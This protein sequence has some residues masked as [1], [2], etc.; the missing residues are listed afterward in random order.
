MVLEHVAEEL[1]EGVDVRHENEACQQQPEVEE[2]AGKDIGVQDQRQEVQPGQAASRDAAALR[3]RNSLAHVRPGGLEEALGGIDEVAVARPLQ[4]SQQDDAG[5]RE[6]RVGEPDGGTGRQRT[7]LRQA[8]QADQ[9]H[10]VQE[11]QENRD[12]ESRG[13]ARLARRSAQGNADHSQQHAGERQREPAVQLDGGVAGLAR[14]AEDRAGI[15]LAERPHRVRVGRMRGLQRLITG[16]KAGADVDLGVLGRLVRAGVLEVKLDAVVLDVGR[17]D[18]LARQSDGRS[19]A[20]FLAVGGA[21][22]GGA[23]I[24]DEDITPDL[25]PARNRILHI[26]NRV[27]ELLLEDARL[28]LG[29]E[30]LGGQPAKQFLGLADG[31]PQRAGRGDHRKENP[32]HQHRRQDAAAGH[33]GRAHPDDFAVARHAAERDQD[34]HQRSGG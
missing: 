33:A 30:L 24:G 16:R 13:L 2:E 29:G 7:L 23:Q 3:P 27:G 22:G 28:H 8:D 1:E 14:G 31:Q 26:E 4:A 21:V 18:H 15:H 20:L 25:G 17:G 6:N 5:H 12:H 32:H 34:A 11:C 9:A 19:L 10:V